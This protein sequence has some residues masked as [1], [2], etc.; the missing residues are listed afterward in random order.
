M[1]D[2]FQGSI[3]WEACLEVEIAVLKCAARKRLG[4]ISGYPISSRFG[5]P[6]R[7]TFLSILRSYT[8]RKA[9][10]EHCIANF[11]NSRSYEPSFILQFCFSRREWKRGAN[12]FFFGCSE[13][14][15]TGNSEV[16]NQRATKALFTCVAYT[17]ANIRI[18]SQS[19]LEMQQA[20]LRVS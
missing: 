20:K 18:Q 19:Q 6:G 4:S 17:M 3:A 5:S 8:T 9:F 10:F 14:K 12:L 15:S 7:I 11:Y 2:K 13:V 1:T 16:A